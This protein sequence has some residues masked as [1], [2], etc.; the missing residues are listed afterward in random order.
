MPIPQDLQTIQLFAGLSENALR[1]VADI[2]IRRHYAANTLIILEGDVCDAAYFVISGEV[3][4]YRISPQGR[5]QV[6]LRLGPGQAFNT[7][8]LFQPE[9]TNHASATA[10]ADVTLYVAPRDGFLRAIRTCHELSM[11]ILRDFAGRLTHL[12][13]MVEDLALHSV[14]GRLARFLLQ[15]ADGEYITRRWTQDDI[16]AHLGTV[17]DMVGRSLRAM[18]DAGWLRMDRGRIVLLDRAALEE[19]SE[20]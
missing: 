19:E 13:D 11:A 3:Q 18:V 15:Q 16:A 7:V 20:R 5:H 1:S 17:R 14:R 12:T 2:A 8:P 10:L 6:L 4:V 9:G